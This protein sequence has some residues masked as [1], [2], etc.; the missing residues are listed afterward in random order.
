MYLHTYYINEIPE[1]G[2][3]LPIEEEGLGQHLGFDEGAGQAHRQLQQAQHRQSYNGYI[4]R[5][6]GSC[7]SNRSRERN[8]SLWGAGSRAVHRQLSV[9]AC[10]CVRC[11]VAITVAE[12]SDVKSLSCGL[13]HLSNHLCV[14][15][16]GAQ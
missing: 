10:A 14:P 16:R 12:V 13:Q 5:S 11:H 6:S 1:E 3:S 9:C 7:C 2:Q 15:L 8:T 4:N